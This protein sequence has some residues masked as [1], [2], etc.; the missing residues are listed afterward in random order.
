[1]VL[2]LSVRSPVSLAD[3]EAAAKRLGPHLSPTPSAHSIVLSE[4]F[5]TQIVLKFENL[6]FTAAF[7][8]RGALNRLLQLTPAQR[9]QGVVAASAGNHAQAI[10]RHA[11]ALG[12]DATIVM[13]RSTPFTK[14]QR[15]KAFGAAV[16][17]AGESVAEATE[18][19]LRLVDRDHRIWVHPF[20]DTAVIAGQGTIALEMLQAHPELDTLIVPVGGGGL[21]AGIAVA[22]RE[23]R[24][25]IRLLGVQTEQWPS[26]AHAIQGGAPP[27]RGPTLADGIAVGQPGVITTPIIRALVDRVLTVTESS[28]EEAITLL[29][30]I[31]KVVVEG[32][33]AVGIAAL[34]ERAHEIGGSH[35]GVVLTGG[36]VDP[37]L[38]SSIIVRGLVRQGRLARLHVDLADS[39]GAL[40]RLTSMV[41]DL[42]GNIVDVRHERIALGVLART[43]RIEL[44]VQTLDREHRETVIRALEGSEFAQVHLDDAYAGHH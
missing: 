21:L 41:G 26:M 7:K 25:N 9:S 33:G 14:V 8:E 32:A 3:V 16:V 13:P 31:E 19:A 23:L 15:T 29:I 27:R 4:I 30:D 20:D 28:I 40:G 5:G 11:A 35:V 37:L 44:V 6:Q 17:L 12:I 1:V 34:I 18:E 39:P 38:L 2:N 22:A 42:G 10:A 43:A 24:P 36:N